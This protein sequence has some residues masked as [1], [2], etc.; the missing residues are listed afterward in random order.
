MCVPLPVHVWR[1]AACVCGDVCSFLML[2]F[3]ICYFIFLCCLPAFLCLW[4]YLT[5]VCHLII[6]CVFVCICVT[7][8][9]N[10]ES[11]KQTELQS[12]NTPGTHTPFTWLSVNILAYFKHLC[13]CVC[14]CVCGD[15]VSASGWGAHQLSEVNMQKVCSVLFLSEPMR[16]L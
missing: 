13:V 10:L 15:G 6:S 8:T 9:A 1:G 14:V 4:A 7:I 16:P 12:E 11:N 2:H 5:F 3:I